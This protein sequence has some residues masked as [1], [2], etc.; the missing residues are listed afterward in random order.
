MEE[1][2]VLMSVYCRE[3]PENLRLAVESILGQTVAP[4]EFVLVCDGP[5]TQELDGVIDEFCA[6][7]PA[8]F[9][10]LRLEENRGLGAALN[11]GLRECRCELVARMDSDDISLPERMQLQLEAWQ[12]QP[13]L[14]ALG[15]QI[16]EFS[17]SPD[18]LLAYRRVPTA[19][20]T[21]R[22]YLK[23]RSPMNHTTTLLRRSHVLQVGGYEEVAGFEDYCLWIKLI[24]RG[25]SLANVPHVCCHVRADD[26]M[27]RRRGG[28]KYFKNAVKMETFLL[29]SGLITVWE[30]AGNVAV[31][32]AGTVLISTKLRRLVFLRFLRL[33]AVEEAKD[34]SGLPMFAQVKRI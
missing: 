33:R 10:I 6:G 32:F 31:R 2:S 3:Q 29:H 4:T 20:E 14:S 24:S 13:G 21:I 9:H 23:R 18:H 22:T 11:A 1:Y 26:G 19:S 25:F 12:Q 34:L 17:H 5:L 30:Y 8:L 16:A 28:W 7:Y 27:Y 15:G